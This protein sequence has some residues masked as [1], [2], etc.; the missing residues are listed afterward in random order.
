MISTES[1]KNLL[2]KERVKAFFEAFYFDEEPA[3]D[4]ELA[5]GDF[6][7]ERRL[8]R[9]ELRLL[10][11]PGQCLACN[12]TWGLPAVFKKHPILDLEGL[13]KETEK[14]LPK[15]LKVKSWELGPTEERS[16]ELHVIPLL[17]YLE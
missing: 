12:L 3:Y 2:P 8:L 1:I 7:E 9:L 4:L 10:A 6:D 15:G 17:I 5:L 11:R 14:F 16:P 13:V